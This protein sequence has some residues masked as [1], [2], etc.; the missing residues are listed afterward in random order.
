MNQLP[1]EQA[2][3]AQWERFREVL[4]SAGLRDQLRSGDA[5]TFLAD[6]QAVT[7]HLALAKARGYSRQLVGRL[8]TLAVRG[9]SAVYAHRSGFLGAF[10]R[11]IFSGF[12][13]AVRAE[14][15]AVAASTALF[16]VPLLGMT[17]Q[18]IQQPDWIYTLLDGEQVSQFEAMYNP[19]SEH[20]GRERASDTAF[21]AFGGY[22]S[23]N[24]SI[25]FRMFAS[26]IFFGIGTIFFPRVQRPDNWRGDRAPVGPWLYGAVFFF[27]DRPR[28]L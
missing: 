11:F 25:S 9:H 14:R 8:N 1:F 27:C 22:V 6:Y 7:R 2:N 24:V 18:I 23:N 16:V 5:Q 4:E 28:F 26:G 21:R 3:Q 19:E 15:W 17:I 10:L 12:P 20:Y 13:A